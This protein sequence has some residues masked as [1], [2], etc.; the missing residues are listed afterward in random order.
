MTSG[1]TTRGLLGLVLL[2]GMS[3][4]SFAQADENVKA[5]AATAGDLGA[6]DES[7][8]LKFA[9]EHHPELAK[10]LGPMK[11]ARPKEYQKAIRELSRVADRLTRMELRAPERYAIEV[12]LWKAESRLRLVAARSAMVDDDDRRE[13]IEKL[14]TERNALKLRLFE[15][16][17]NEASARISQLDKQI[18]TLKAQESDAVRKEVDRLVNTAKSSAKRVKTK[19]ES[20]ASEKPKPVNPKRAPGATSASQ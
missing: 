19:V 6:D 20:P 16:E 11:S 1:L 2:I 15:F 9:R 10:L 14:V 13:Q 18:E 7:S 17:R 12:D 5:P 3:S 4:V 8:A